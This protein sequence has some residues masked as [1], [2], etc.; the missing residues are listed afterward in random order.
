MD[1]LYI[2]QFVN[3]TPFF[4]IWFIKNNDFNLVV[5]LQ[6]QAKYC[7]RINIDEMES[8]QTKHVIIHLSLILHFSFNIRLK[9]CSL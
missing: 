3:L 5:R 9:M 7:L 1:I 6:F 4:L 2:Y 8:D